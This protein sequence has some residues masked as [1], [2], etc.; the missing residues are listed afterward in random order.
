MAATKEELQ[1]RIAHFKKMKE[2]NYDCM[3]NSVYSQFTHMARG[4]DG[5]AAMEG[6][7]RKTYYPTWENSD[8]QTVCMVMG[9]D[10]T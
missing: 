2:N 7:I 1:G 10:Y 6:E 8:F 3:L 9:W 5:T 4:G